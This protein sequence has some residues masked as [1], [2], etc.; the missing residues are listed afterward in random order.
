MLG[1]AV[2]LGPGWIKKFVIA[3]F[4]RLTSLRSPPSENVFGFDQVDKLMP[5]VAHIAAISLLVG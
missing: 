3:K 1:R 2:T 4:N 5:E